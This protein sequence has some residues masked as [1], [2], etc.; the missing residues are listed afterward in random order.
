VWA[1][2]IIALIVKP[3]GTV[4]TGLWSGKKSVFV[5]LLGTLCTDCEMF[6]GCEWVD[7]YLVWGDI[8]SAGF[9]CGGCTVR[10]I[11]RSVVLLIFITTPHGRCVSFRSHCGAPAQS[12]VTCLSPGLWHRAVW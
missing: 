8:R 2:R 4:T 11:Q 3:D 9:G 1:E 7:M 5:D 6:W 12:L 10:G